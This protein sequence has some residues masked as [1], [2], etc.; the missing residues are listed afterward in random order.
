MRSWG[1]RLL[2]VL[3]IVCL[4]GAA[5]AAPKAKAKAKPAKAAATPAPTTVEG[6]L[7]SDQL[8]GA[9]VGVYVKSLADG[10][11]VFGHN[12]DKPFI[13]ASTNKVVTGA[14]ALRTL[15]PKYQYRT[16]VLADSR[17]SVDGTINGNLYVKGYGDPS[18]TLEEA[19]LI[20]HQ[21]RGLGVKTVTGDIVGD[22]T[23]FSPEGFYDRSV[24]HYANPSA[25]VTPMG[26]LAINFNTVMGHVA[27][28]PKDGA[29][30][31]ATLDPANDFFTIDNQVTTCESCRPVITMR[32]E[33]RR[34][35]LMGKARVGME[36][37]SGFL[38][39]SD[40]TAFSMSSLKGLLANEGVTVAG[41]AREGVAPEGARRLLVHESRELSLMVRYLFRYSNNFTAEQ[42]LKTMGAQRHGAPGDREKGCSAVM[43]FLASEGIPTEG[44]VIA[45]GSGLS[46]N[47]RQTPASMLGTLTWAA[48]KPEIFPEFLEALA[49]GGVDG[50]MSR[51]FRGTALEGRVRAKTGYVNGVITLAG[52]VWD[53]RGEPYAFAILVNDPPPG[54]SV[55]GVRNAMDR[56][57]L[58]LMTK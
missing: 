55:G 14:A 21:I 6:M 49:I 23:Y 29:P 30:A 36:P 18:I 37:W 4:G 5:D 50:T 22:A 10:R 58:L 26:A 7:E 8:K 51:R 38:P 57:L 19:W 53:T 34:A 2:L 39:V 20:A 31:L 17:V 24:W 11:T 12:I 16:E 1:S 35:V 46:R 40:A 27:A 41:T 9:K 44:V 54:A 56:I 25:Y 3:L 33:G 45:D 15:G 42:L 47:N 43:D 13:P 28:G 52:Y 32:L 48:S